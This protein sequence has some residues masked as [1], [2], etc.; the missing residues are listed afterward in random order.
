MAAELIYA[1]RVMRLPLLDTAGAQIGRIQDIVAVAG[2]PGQPPRVVGFVEAPAIGLDLP[3]DLRGTAFQQRVW[4]ALREIPVGQTASYAE[5]AQR[6][7]SP[8]AVRGVAWA[9]A[10][11]A[12]A[13]AIPCHRVVRADG[14]VGD[15]MFGPERK[16]QLLRAEHAELDVLAG[17]ARRGVHFLGSDS[18]GIVCFPTC[19]NARRISAAHRREFRTVAG[20][21]AAG[22]RPCHT[23]RPVTA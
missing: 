19:H 10:A 11:N 4:Q 23:C 20:A 8:K 3:L 12:L 22:Y 13:V 15:Y 18:T 17:Y 5:I 9:C 21:L 7:G 2:R 6:I 16:E 1:F 14:R